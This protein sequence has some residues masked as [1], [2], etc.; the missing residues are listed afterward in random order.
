V[1]MNEQLPAKTAV[2]TTR[3]ASIAATNHDSPRPVIAVIGT[4]RSGTSLCA[5]ARAGSR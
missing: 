1:A 5:H 3:G 4:H 2:L